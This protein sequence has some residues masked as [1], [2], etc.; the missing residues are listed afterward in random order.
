MATATQ[1]DVLTR[2][3][4]ELAKVLTRVFREHRDAP[5][6][7]REAAYLRAQFPAVCLEIRAQ[8]LFAGRYLSKRPVTF[9]N[10]LLCGGSTP[11]NL[12]S[13][14]R[15]TGLVQ[16]RTPESQ[17]AEDERRLR[18][19]T[20]ISNSGFSYNRPQLM[21]MALSHA[22]GSEARRELEQILSFWEEHASIRQ[23]LQQLPGEI[24]LNLGRTD[25]DLRYSSSF[26][27]VCCLSCD[28][29]KLLQLGV[30]GLVALIRSKRSAAESEDAVHLYNGMLMALQA[31]KDVCVHYRDEASRKAVSE[32]DPTRRAQLVAMAEAL[33]RITVS[34]P[35]SLR[36]AIQLFWLYTLCAD[37][38]NFGRMDVYLG[39]FFAHDIDNGVL[40]QDEA[41]ELL[42][43]LWL[44]IAD[45]A[46]DGW[47]QV[48]HN[49]RIIV[50]G[51][52]RRN[53]A[54]AD[55][56]ALS[57]MN[58][59]LAVKTPEPNLTLR[60]YAGQNPALMDRALDLL[61]AGCVHPGLYNDDAHIPMVE[62]AYN[63]PAEEAEHYI[64]EGCGEI[65]IDHK[66]VGSPN[67]IINYIDALEFVLH[68]GFSTIVGERRGLAL[69]EPDSFKTFESLVAAVEKQ[70][71]YTNDLF[72]RRHALE[73][74]VHAEQSAFL[75]LSMLTDDCIARGKSLFGGGT[76][77]LGG[78]IETFGLTN[79]A[80]S[81]YAIK[82]VVYDR[83][84]LSL[85]ELVA[86]LDANFEGHERER[87]M[88]LGLPKFGND[89]DRVDALHCRLS[90]F[91][92]RSAFEKAA[93]HGLHFFLNCNLN[94]GG[95]RYARMSK[96]SADGR[97]A[98]DSFA[99]GNAP[100]AGR[101]RNGPTA[102]LNSMAKHEKLHCGYVQNLKVSKSM[103]S[104]E[105]R[106]KLCS[107][108]DAY[109]A[110]DGLQAMVTTVSREELEDA[111][112]NPEQHG[113]LLVRIG[114]WTAR[115]VGLQEWMQ[116]EI[117][118]RTLY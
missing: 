82:H 90:S 108:L 21:W 36:E 93:K 35:A 33:D 25:E 85:S 32:P 55:R 100:T 52:G 61:A 56:F 47:F 109:F 66:S 114:G 103:F 116:D 92:C 8:D 18:S 70:I 13:R 101:D 77:Y 89:D 26:F 64:P 94:P 96:A 28:F 10:E 58:V 113:N 46:P 6:P 68:N 42:K 37:T 97:K 111:K 30:P 102:L 72:A 27:R 9:S 38:P 24:R 63:V 71:D 54:N 98:G 31:L 106:P 87:Q 60:F 3:R 40:T 15:G 1:P 105:N 84:I 65:Q 78:Q 39:D 104:S 117:I 12:K 115:F 23:Y 2:K 16:D 50:G 57:A 79:L 74:R 80:D 19:V 48:T 118:A 22:P 99:V 17:V 73:H 75:F 34:K 95:I 51:K 43:S 112:Q 5:V 81:L 41:E 88:L 67:N 7:L 49:A 20:G 110:N 4:I 14:A 44:L 29:D 45:L 62:K 107:M 91:V 69:G 76:R 53:E 83:K 11:R 59:T 86:I